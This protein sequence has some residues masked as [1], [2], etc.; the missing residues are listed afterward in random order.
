MPW[1]CFPVG[2]VVSSC[3]DEEEIQ[4]LV[5]ILAALLVSLLQWRSRTTRE[6]E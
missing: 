3:R 1:N 6:E 5:V 4:R 2:D